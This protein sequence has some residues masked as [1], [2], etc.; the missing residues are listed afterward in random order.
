MF[1]GSRI[2]DIFSVP[3]FGLVPFGARAAGREAE[4][5]WGSWM[6]RW[7]G[8]RPAVSWGACFPLG[9]VRGQVGP[10]LSV[11]KGSCSSGKIITTTY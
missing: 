2:P 10:R 8:Q 6:P 7:P 4:R 1:L 9:A 5:V 11:A 3:A